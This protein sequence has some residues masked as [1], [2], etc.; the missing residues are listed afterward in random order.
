MLYV[1]HG[2]DA[3]K[4]THK[5]KAL[6]DSLRAKKPDAAFVYIDSE[7]W[8]GSIIEEH[9]GGQGLFSNKYIIQL[10]RLTENDEAKETLP[11]FVEAMQESANIFIVSEGKLPADLKKAFEKHAEKVVEVADAATAKKQ[12]FNVF[13]L[14]DAFGARDRAKSW[15]LYREAIDRGIE[16]ENVIGTL[17]WQ[18]KSIAA[19]KEAST[20]A[21]AGLSPF[22][23]TKSKRYAGNFSNEGIRHVLGELIRLYHDGHR[24]ADLEL[25]LESF[26]LR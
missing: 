7:H 19:S 18:A 10:D 23:F 6:I 12:E 3:S 21:E 14:G 25:G 4:A 17:F 5:A 22:V 13:A 9:L 1:F 11:D 8:H 2:T 15:Y 24:G 16:P 20:A 26:L